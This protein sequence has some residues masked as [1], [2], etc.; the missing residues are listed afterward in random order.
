[1]A[2][3]EERPLPAGSTLIEIDASGAV[4]VQQHQ[5]DAAPYFRE[6]SYPEGVT[7]VEPPPLDGLQ[8]GQRV[9]Q[10]AK[11]AQAAYNCGSEPFHRHL[12]R[13]IENCRPAWL[14]IEPRDKRHINELWQSRNLAGAQ[15]ARAPSGRMFYRRV[16]IIALPARDPSSHPVAYLLTIDGV[17]SIQGIA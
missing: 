5:G 4:R 15:V 2:T 8:S 7:I 12:D 1:M 16:P 3:F 13:I 17:R 11:G 9:A 14:A 6:G 10:F